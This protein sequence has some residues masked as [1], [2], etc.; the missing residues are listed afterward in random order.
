MTLAIILGVYFASCT[1]S[2][3]GSV[4]AAAV[5]DERKTK[6]GTK[7]PDSEFPISFFVFF[8]IVN[9]L[10]GLSWLLRGLYCCVR[11]VFVDCMKDFGLLLIVAWE[12]IKFPF[13]S[14]E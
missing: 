3:I 8:P 11:Y 9:T 7:H 6:W 12:F 4:L 1:L 5:I 13:T 10:I 2:F 14:E